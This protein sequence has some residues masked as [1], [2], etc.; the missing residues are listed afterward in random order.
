VNCSHQLTGV[1]V[2]GFQGKAITIPFQLNYFQ[3]TRIQPKV[4]INHTYI[5]SNILPTVFYL[6]P[7][8]TCHLDPS[9]DNFFSD[10][11]KQCQPEH[12]WQPSAYELTL[13]NAY[14]VHR[15]DALYGELPS[16]RTFLRLSYDVRQFD[17][18]VTKCSSVA[19]QSN[20]VSH[21]RLG[22][23]HNPL[24]EYAW[25]MTARELNLPNDMGTVQSSS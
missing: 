20:F 1:H 24:F 8:R 18:F 25:A 11:A 15:G 14:C 19:P 2:D 17:R 9:R 4:V 7:F 22:N 3:G 5:C 6:Q 12:I 13:M 23:T 16:Y 21:L 10:F